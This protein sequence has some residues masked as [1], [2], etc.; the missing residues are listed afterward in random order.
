MNLATVTEWCL[1]SRKPADQVFG[2]FLAEERAEL[3]RLLSQFGR[4]RSPAARD[5]LFQTMLL[6]AL[7][8]THATAS[9]DGGHE[10]TELMRTQARAQQLAA[11]RG[12]MSRGASSRE[13]PS[14]SCSF[15]ML[16][17]HRA[18]RQRARPAGILVEGVG[19]AEAA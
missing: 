6:A 15:L 8:V 14:G 5:D 11:V 18:P 16:G 9:T 12:A 17:E 13:V 2:A 4:Y 1:E 10:A 7:E 3:G 19:P